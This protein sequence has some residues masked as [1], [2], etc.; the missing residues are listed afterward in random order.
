MS[1]VAIYGG[2]FDPIHNGHL[3]VINAVTSMASPDELLIFPSKVSPNKTSVIASDSDR[4]E[5][6]NLALSCINHG[7]TLI[8]ID[9]FELTQPAPSY[10]IR[11][12]RHLKNRYPANTQLA[13]VIGYDNYQHFHLWD[14]YEH[15]LSLLTHL[16]IVNRPGFEQRNAILETHYHHKIK[17]ITT[18]EI[19]ISSS[20]IRQELSQR[21]TI[22]SH[23]PEAVRQYID[24]QKLYQIK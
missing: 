2:S 13:L 5:M 18:K 21:N 3:T 19:P 1:L 8:K 10:T 11:T 16:L 4:L 17:F 22:S 6:I 7:N 14:D 9:P 23:V 20:Q 12:I 15:L 24:T